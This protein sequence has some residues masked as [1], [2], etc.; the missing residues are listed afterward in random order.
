MS[1]YLW[2]NVYRRDFQNGFVLVNPGTTS[3]T[4]NLGG[5]YQLV[6]A[7]GG[8]TMTDSQID[9]NGNYIGG[10]LTY[11]TVSSVTLAGGTAAIFLKPAAA[12]TA[13]A[14]AAVAIR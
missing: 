8:G 3:Y 1:S 4:L 10:S 14:N 11:Q 6:I 7:S 13:S 5:T 9:A 2:N 12:M